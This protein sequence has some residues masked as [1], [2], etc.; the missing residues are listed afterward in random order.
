[1]I[2]ISNSART[3]STML[4]GVILLSSGSARSQ[5]D[6]YYPSITEPSYEE[7]SL[8]YSSADGSTIRA[9]SKNLLEPS[10]DGGFTTPLIDRFRGGTPLEVISRSD[11]G[12]FGDPFDTYQ[13]SDYS[14]TNEGIVQWA[15]LSGTL[16]EAETTFESF[17]SYSTVDIDLTR[18]PGRI[19][20]PR[21]ATIGQVITKTF[22]QDVESLTFSDLFDLK[23]VEHSEILHR[24]VWL[25]T[26]VVE[27]LFPGSSPLIVT[28]PFTALVRAVET[29]ITGTRETFIIN[30]EGES[31]MGVDSLDTAPLTT[32]EW[33]VKGVGIVQLVLVDG[34]WIDTF[35]ARS[36]FHN[37]SGVIGAVSFNDLIT[38][39]DIIYK[40]LRVSG[41]SSNDASDTLLQESEQLIELWP[42]AVVSRLESIL[43]EA[44][45]SGG[46]AHPAAIPFNDGTS[47]ALKYAFNMSLTGPDSRTLAPEGT[48]GLPAL[49]TSG[50]GKSGVLQLEYLRRK[51]D[52]LHYFP[53]MS[54][55]L[56]PTDFT[57]LTGEEIVSEIDDQFER[58]TLAI[59]GNP[60]Q[61]KALFL[62]VRVSY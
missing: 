54:S 12:D 46:D 36:V 55:S 58:V 23:T 40:Q 47:N 1:M 33:V 17:T 60:D 48:A 9:S 21:K 43:V 2:S 32:F 19:L 18:R 37:G 53:E 35:Q 13:R 31:S 11:G 57:A 51:D 28:E 39:D 22:P 14:V 15:G 10:G 4:G 30:E 25:G 52:V 24:S 61:E 42:A 45:L 50:S 44:G 20:V 5:I 38:E 29:S 6:S 59:P 34:E 56:D 3:F 7:S 8:S 16:G 27:S 62:R 41:G 26:D 49:R